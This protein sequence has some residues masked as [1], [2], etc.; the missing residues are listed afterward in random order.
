[1]LSKQ[2]FNA[3]NFEP[4]RLVYPSSW[5][6][7]IPF[8]HFVVTVLRPK[9][10]VELGVHSGNSFCAFCQAVVENRLT[11]E[12]KCY[13]IDTFQGEVHSGFYD[14][15]VYV[16]IKGFVTDNFPDFAF[17]RKG[18]FAENIAKFGDGSIDLLHI[19]G[20]HTYDEV[21]NDFN[22][23]LPKVSNNGVVLFHDIEVRSGDFG[24]WR[25]WEEIKRDFLL[26]FEFSYG[27]GLGVLVLAENELSN[28][29]AVFG[30]RLE[31]S[32]QPAAI[33]LQNQYEKQQLVL[34]NYELTAERDK[35]WEARLWF[36]HQYENLLES[37][38]YC[39]GSSLICFLRWDNPWFHFRQLV[40]FLIPVCLMLRIRE[41]KGSAKKFYNERVLFSDFSKRCLAKFRKRFTKP[42]KISQQSWSGPLV[43]V[44]VTCYNYGIYLDRVLG[45]LEA[46]SWHNFEIIFIDDGSTDPETIV[47]VD[48]LK[49]LQ[50]PNLMVMQQPNQ[51]VIAARNNAIAKAR[52]KYIFPLDADDTIEKTFL[53]KC[54]FFLENSPEHFFVYAWTSSAGADEFIWETRDSS[55]VSVLEENR[56]GCAVFRKTAFS[57]VG[58]Y[59]PVMADGYEDWELC[60][61]LVAHGY[62][63]RVIKEPLYHYYVKPGTR[64]YHAIKKHEALKLK[65]GDLHRKTI[66]VQEKRLLRLAHQ[67]YQVNHSLVNL[68]ADNRAGE[69]SILL[70]LYKDDGLTPAILK[71]IVLKVEKFSVAVLL[72]LDRRWSKFFILPNPDNLF[73]YYPEEYHPEHDVEPFYNYL[74]QRYQPQR[75]ALCDL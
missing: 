26:T 41:L 67:S 19:D 13:G 33:K 46:Q 35:L 53:E 8:A 12:T 37:E 17:L 60:A 61:N 10:V 21:K 11:S 70:D 62:I 54:L 71:D 75:V 40:R 57:Q 20:L 56:M 48:E 63:G 52:G 44:I 36:E 28:K 39:L 43:S 49:K 1:M 66:K 51:G 25:L 34:E 30:A 32:F 31:K 42:I 65:I 27:H 72:T 73:V 59:N 50:Q 18:T 3:L 68:V 58:G 4:K 2:L 6:Q 74:Q 14:E 38:P 9:L 22:V 5:I 55:P 64:N 69:K 47:R 29:L 23:W 15:S 24:V 45:C 7:H 16:D